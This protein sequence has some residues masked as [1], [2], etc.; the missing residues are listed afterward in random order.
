M[1]LS[2]LFSIA[3]L[4]VM[5]EGY[6]QADSKEPS[7]QLSDVWHTLG[8]FMRALVILSMYLLDADLY[9]LI[10][11]GLVMWPIYNVACNL[12]RKQHPL[13]LSDHGIDKL[14]KKVLFFV[15]FPKSK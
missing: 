12:G 9:L 15:K 2:I 3:L 10:A 11:A 7:E 4:I 13:Y 14:I 5:R 1:I 6:Q 8:W